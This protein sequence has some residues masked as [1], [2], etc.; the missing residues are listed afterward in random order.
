MATRA[1]L[2]DLVELGDMDELIRTVDALVD[3]RDWDG[4]IELRDRCRRALDRGKQ[5]WPIASL[6]EYRAALDA[7]GP[8]RRRC[9]WSAPAT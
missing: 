3:E 1:R 9:S 8:G 4:L 2:E 6:C 7:P 5:L